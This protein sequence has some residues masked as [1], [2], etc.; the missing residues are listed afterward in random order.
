[1]IRWEKRGELFHQVQR[2]G[3]WVADSYLTPAGE[4]AIAGV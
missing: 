2:W 4:V 3:G 1:L